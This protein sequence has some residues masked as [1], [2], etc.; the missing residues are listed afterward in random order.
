MKKHLGKTSLCKPVL[1]S[2]FASYTM[3]QK[4]ILSLVPHDKN[5]EQ[6]IKKNEMIDY[7]NKH[8]EN[9]RKLIN[10]I[11]EANSKECYYCNKTFSKNMYLRKHI[12]LECFY[13]DMVEEDNKRCL[14]NNTTVNNLKNNSKSN[15]SNNSNNTN[16]TTVNNNNNCNNTTVNNNN[17]N[18]TIN[19]TI[20]NNNN[21]INNTINNNVTINVDKRIVS[22]NKS[23][24]L[25]EIK[26]NGEK[27]ELLCS[28]ILYTNFLS[29][30]LENKKNLN[31]ILDKNSKYGFVYDDESEQFINMTVND[32]LKNSM[33]KLRD[34]L[35]QI[36]ESLI[37]YTTPN[38]NFHEYEKSINKLDSERTI[39]NKYTY[40]NE[41]P[42]K[43]D[44]ANYHILNIY[45]K[46]AEIAAE[47]SKK[48]LND[49]KIMYEKN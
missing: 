9:R 10:R 44:L 15:N 14:N 43:R 4:L 40:Y 5:N 6:I 27:L 42:E 18:N 17:C 7:Q 25:S 49:T 1:N 26:T 32:I 30:L 35:L 39:R 37:N 16:N 21:T 13:V 34:N 41:E 47:N 28:E 3:D 20:N 38:T 8:I 12:L 46:H 23:W 36:N 29:K 11:T 31:V 24:D 45:D 22:F 19:N 48:L 2:Y 33:K